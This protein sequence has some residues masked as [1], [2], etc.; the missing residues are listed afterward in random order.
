MAILS[1]AEIMEVQDITERK[2]PIPEWGGEVVVRSISHRQMRDLKKR[3]AKEVGDDDEERQ[4]DEVEKQIFLEGLVNPKIT[5][6]EFEHILNKSSSAVMKILNG[7]LGASGGEE[8]AVNEEEKN[9][10]AESE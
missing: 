4:N 10:P 2:I 5:D 1:I 9:F 8:N 7:I 6:E 3:V